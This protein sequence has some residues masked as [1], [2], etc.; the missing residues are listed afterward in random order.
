MIYADNGDE[1]LLALTR[2]KFTRFPLQGQKLKHFHQ[3]VRRPKGD[4]GTNVENFSFSAKHRG[5]VGVSV[6]DVFVKVV[7]QGVDVAVGRYLVHDF[8]FV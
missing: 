7:R 2:L 6:A 5:I 1:C 8:A 3:Y 4:I